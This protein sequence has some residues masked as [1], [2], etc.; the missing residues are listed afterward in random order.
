MNNMLRD[1][2][3]WVGYV[4]WNLRDFHGY[5]TSR[6]STYNAY[7][8]RDQKVALI[9]TVKG[10]YAGDLLDHIRALTDPA[11]VD[12]IICNHAEP[13]HSGAL[14]AAVR[15]CPSAEVVCDGKCRDT[16][17]SY[18]D[19]AGWRWRIVRGGD[20]LPLGK[21]SLTFIE[22]PMVHW[23]ESMLTYCPEE[24]ILFSNDA[25]GQHLAA[26]SRFDDEVDL[27]IAL[28]EARKYYANILMLYGAPIAKTLEKAAGLPIEIIAPSHGVIWRKNLPAIIEAYRGWT[29]LKAVPKVLVIYDSMWESTAQMAQAIVEGACQPGVEARLMHARRTDL[30]DIATEVLDAA[31]LAFGSPTLNGQMMPVMA[32]VM[33]YLKGLR[34]ANKPAFAFGSYGWAKGGTK[35]LTEAMAAMKLDI[36][37]EPIT[38]AY[39]PTPAVLEECRSAGQMLAAKALAVS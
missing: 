15:A 10:L 9:D 38:A 25:F 36:V 7:L 29:R 19:M 2:I 3:D 33:G 18:Y 22:A 31:C 5:T 4:D 34:P 21:R 17:S 28:D 11:K 6:G 1:N 26:S 39:R 14:P 12:Y 30:T 13:D 16:L 24:K 35:D 23:P 32:A 20:V 8:V 37:R 27:R